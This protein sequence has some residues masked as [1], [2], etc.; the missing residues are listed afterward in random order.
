[1]AIQS[2]VFR[3]VGKAPLLMHNGS[4]ADPT[5]P[6]VKAMKAIT[7]NRKKTDEQY[8]QLALLEFRG[9]LYLNREGKVI[10]PSAVIEGSIRDGAKKSK[11]GKQFA[12]AVMVNDDAL[13]D[14]G[15]DL[16]PEEMFAQRDKYVST[17]AVRVEKNR[18]M[19][20]RPIFWEWSLE[21]TVDWD[22]EQINA[23]NLRKAVD[24]AGV[25]VGIGDYRPKYGRFDVEE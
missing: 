15:D 7:G 10:V 25:L 16:T 13:L 6:I 5:N 12:S 18:I 9:G 19:R 24:D 4:L 8:E 14:Y 22:N 23:N 17:M 1:M 21:F 2:T 3:I 11:L 20:T